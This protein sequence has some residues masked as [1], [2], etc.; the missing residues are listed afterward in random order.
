MIIIVTV[1]QPGRGEIAF[2]KITDPKP[3]Q[4]EL[5]ISKALDAWQ[6]AI[7]PRSPWPIEI[8]IREASSYP[9]GV[10]RLA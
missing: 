8:S 5:A 7:A 4:V 10:G 2:I 1:S 6:Q 3:G 9:S